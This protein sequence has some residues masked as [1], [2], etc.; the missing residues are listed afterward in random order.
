[1]IIP[2][3][4]PT[5]EAGYSKIRTL[6]ELLSDDPILQE[7]KRSKLTPAL[8]GVGLKLRDAQ[9][10]ALYRDLDSNG[11]GKVS[12]Q[13]GC[14]STLN[15]RPLCS[16]PLLS[17]PLPPLTS[18]SLRLFEQSS[19]LTSTSISLAQTHRSNIS[20]KFIVQRRYR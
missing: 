20:P 12:L 1:M 16:S 18:L 4:N 11:D 14:P 13:S 17:S 19:P 5:G 2:T 7:V 9:A 15:P 10:K 8:K 6:F 3:S